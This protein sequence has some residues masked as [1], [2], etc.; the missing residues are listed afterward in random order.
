[1]SLFGIQPLVLGPMPKLNPTKGTEPETRS[2]ETPTGETPT[3]KA[4]KG[5]PH[6]GPATPP[7]AA[8]QRN[9][10]PPDFFDRVS[11]SKQREKP[12]K[13]NPFRER[14]VAHKLWDGLHTLGKSFGVKNGVF[15]IKIKF[16]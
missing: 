1:M 9:S 16:G 10:L 15:G 5:T 3:N 2:G 7:A 12:E 11:I 4:A 6:Q 13:Q 14:S 8:P